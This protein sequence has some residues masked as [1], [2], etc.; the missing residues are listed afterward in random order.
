MS[1]DSK[2]LIALV[3]INNICYSENKNKKKKKKKNK[4]DRSFLNEAMAEKQEQQE[5][6]GYQ[7]F[8]TSV[9][10]LIEKE[11]FRCYLRMNTRSCY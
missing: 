7:I 11:E 1:S 6:I 9:K 5:R 2:N 10:L 8:T 4:K 3:L